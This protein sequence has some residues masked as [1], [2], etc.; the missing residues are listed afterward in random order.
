VDR[1]RFIP[2]S[3]L[4]T[5]EETPEEQWKPH[6][7][8]NQQKLVDRHRLGYNEFIATA[9][10]AFGAFLSDLETSGKLQNTTVMVSA[11]HG[12]SFE[13]GIYQHRSVSQTRP[14]LH[15]PLIIRR[16]DQQDGYRVAFTADQTA[17][18]PT[19]LELAGLAKPEWMRGQSLV[20]WLNRNGQGD[21]EGMAFA[22]YLEKNSIFM[23][24]RH[25]TVGV[26]DG[27]YQYELDLATN[28]GSLRPL[29]EAHVWN[30]DRSGEH[31]ERVE[32]LRA[33]I[34]ARFPEI[35][36]KPS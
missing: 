10:R 28:K 4:R 13:G 20:S 29:K 12:E 9:D 24:L 35:R 22:Q 5:F 31:P 27:S 32:A 34:Y 15:V 21:G 25:G 7:K 18:A 2:D 19:I 36:Q 16:P 11:D 8:P 26:I 33:A 30:L 17:L 14:V 6:Y 3:E 23:P 1:A